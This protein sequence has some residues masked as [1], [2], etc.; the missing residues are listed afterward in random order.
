M[1][2][3]Y[4][5]QHEFFRN[6]SPTNVALRQS[7]YVQSLRRKRPTVLHEIAATQQ[8]TEEAKA[9]LD[10]ALEEISAAFSPS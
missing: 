5:L 4:A 10:I 1:A 6:V 7:I 8:L 9:A 3:L 2:I